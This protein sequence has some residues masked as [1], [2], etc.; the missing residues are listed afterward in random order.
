MIFVLLLVVLILI[1]GYFSAAEIAMVS[2]KRFRI[3][4]E[5]DK[6]NKHALEVL[7]LL[8]NPEEYLSAIQVGITLVGIIEGLYGGEILQ[9]YLEPKLS[10]LGLS[11]LF[12]HV[13]SIV[14]GVGFI[15]YITIILGELLPKSIAL[16]LPQRIALRIAPSFRLFTL[17]AY[18]FVTFLTKSTHLLLKVFRIK[19][20]ENQKLT[21]ADLKSFLSLAYRQGTIEKV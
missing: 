20:S 17:I 1:N 14:L 15:T 12:S 13:L 3:Q 21:D 5:A 18:P 19:G 2:V 11:S 16:Q 6:G 4:Q 8:Q 10:G 7:S 9:Q